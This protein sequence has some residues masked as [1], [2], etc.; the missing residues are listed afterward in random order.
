MSGRRVSRERPP[1][2]TP[3]TFD[4]VN[5]E[6]GAAVAHEVGEGENP[7]LG[8]RTS[9]VAGLVTGLSPISATYAL[10]YRRPTVEDLLGRDVVR[11]YEA[12]EAAARKEARESTR[13]QRKM[14]AFG[15]IKRETS[16]TD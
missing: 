12:K 8:G 6:S 15:I 7:L 1:A 2:E 10:K 14:A 5:S 9:L 16:A 3:G 13:R 11:V 4:N